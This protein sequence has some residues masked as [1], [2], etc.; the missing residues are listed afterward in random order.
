MYLVCLLSVC[1]GYKTDAFL[2]VYYGGNIANIHTPG[3]EIGLVCSA[4][5]VDLPNNQMQYKI[6]RT[7]HKGD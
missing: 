5:S 2:Q 1:L 7:R 3:V 6:C 4:L